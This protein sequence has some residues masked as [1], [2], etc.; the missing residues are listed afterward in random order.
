M[1]KKIKMISDTKIH[2]S[3]KHDNASADL[4]IDLDRFETQY[5]RAQY[6]LDSM[7]MTD[8][9]PYMPLVTNTFINNTKARSE[10][11]AGSGYV[12][13]A[14]PPYGRF[15]YR[16]KVMVDEKTGSPYAR[17]GA[18]KVLVSQY[19]GKTNAKE[20]IEFSKEAHPKVSKEWFEKAKKI[21]G[22]TW[23]RKVRHAAGGGRG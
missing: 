8:M 1:A 14:A 22:D 18:K 15:L 23:E 2:S 13:A 5:Q 16:G 10:A 21:H 11:I 6:L 3:I 4:Y 20:D 17:M 9:I 12:Y 19:T 7:V